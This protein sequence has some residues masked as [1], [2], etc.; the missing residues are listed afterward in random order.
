[1]GRNA[2]RVQDILTGFV[3]IMENVRERVPEKGMVV[4]PVTRDTMERHALNAR[5]DIT[6]RIEIRRNYF[7]RL[8]MQLVTVI[9]KDLDHRTVSSALT[10]G[11][12]SRGRVVL[13][14]MNASEVTST[15]L[16]INFALTKK[17]ISHAWHAIN[18]VTDAL[19][20]V[21]ICVSDVLMGT[22]RRTIFVS[23]RIFWVASG[24]KI[25]R[26]TPHTSACV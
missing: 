2:L 23:I 11:I 13:T 8:V 10:D 7:V 12:S 16:A 15:V 24:T 25:S 21:L 9:A 18:L 3:T 22:I 26:V 5:K 4:A 1:M 20:M 14:L 17:E 6:S 19:A